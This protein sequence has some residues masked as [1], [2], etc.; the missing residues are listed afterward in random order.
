VRSAHNQRPEEHARSNT[1]AA[2][3]GSQAHNYTQRNGSNNNDAPD[4][5]DSAEAE[6]IADTV[7]AP[8]RRKPRKRNP[9][10][11]QPTIPQRVPD[12]SSSTD[13]SAAHASYDWTWLDSITLADVANLDVTVLTPSSG[14]AADHH[15]QVLA[16]GLTY[17]AKHRYSERGVRGYKFAAVANLAMCA[18]PRGT[19]KPSNDALR[20]NITSAL[21][22][23]I[24]AGRSLSLTPPLP[25]YHHRVPPKRLTPTCLQ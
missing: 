22:G 8:A 12:A 2:S 25:P 21:Y 24:H 5:A 17:A 19:D 14:S 13:F 10:P 20:K 1:A 4:S 15:G 18:F 11:T 16:F 6:D 23:D 3:L 7:P 9:K